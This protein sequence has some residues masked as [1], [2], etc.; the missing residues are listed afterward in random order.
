MPGGQYTNLYEQAKALGLEG[1]WPEVCRMYAQVNQ[2]FG[3]IIKV[4]PTSKV[5]GDMALFMVGNDLTPADVLDDSASWPFPSQLWNSVR[6]GSDNHPVAFRRT[7]NSVCSETG[8]RSETVLAPACRL[9]TS[10]RLGNSGTA[11]PTK[12]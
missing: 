12:R 1:C 3:D 6:A 9:L 5:V 4:T 10:L 11:V 2:M 7:C 8:G